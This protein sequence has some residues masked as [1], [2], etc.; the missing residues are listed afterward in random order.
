MVC[1][2]Y[3]NILP[4]SLHYEGFTPQLLGVLMDAL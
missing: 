3:N 1:G 4:E 2:E